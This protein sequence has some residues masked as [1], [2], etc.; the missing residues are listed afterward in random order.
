MGEG[1]N[2]P[3]NTDRAVIVTGTLGFTSEIPAAKTKGL[4]D[5]LPITHCLM[6]GNHYSEEVLLPG[7]KSYEGYIFHNEEYIV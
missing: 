5:R 4:K 1:V 3:Q 6:K 2:M 7:I